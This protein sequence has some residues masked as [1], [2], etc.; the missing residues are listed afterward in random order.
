MTCATASTPTRATPRSRRARRRPPRTAAR[1][2][3]RSARTSRPFDEGED[4]LL[5]PTP[6]AEAALDRLTAALDATVDDL[7]R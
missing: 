1:V 3:P 2:P 7:T 6:E 4:L 5:S